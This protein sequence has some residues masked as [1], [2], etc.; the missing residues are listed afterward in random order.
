[1]SSDGRLAV[2]HRFGAPRLLHRLRT[3]PADQLVFLVVAWNAWSLRATTDN[4]AYL[5]DASVHEQMVRFASN[6]VRSGSLPVSRWFPFLNL[7]SPQFLHYQG[8][9][10][11]LTG[12]VG[13]FTG[14]DTAFR[15]SLYLM[16]VMWPLVIYH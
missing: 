14:A 15:W 10:A 1:M 3:Q 16:V 6:S 7:G 9:G 12:I 8:L 13:E 4:V 2:G 11:T 5:D